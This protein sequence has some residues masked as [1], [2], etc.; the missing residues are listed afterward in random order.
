[1]K[2]MGQPDELFAIIYLDTQ[3]R[4]INYEV[5]FKGSL[6]QTSVYPRVVVRR[7]LE[8]NAAAMVMAHNHPSGIPT[9]SEADRRLTQTL[10][11]A[12]MLIDVRVLD[13]IIIGEGK[14]Y[15][16]AQHGDI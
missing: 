15:S 9:P 5:L 14:P 11:D 16:F 3:H 13:H 4:V 1:M 12:L 8:M 10:R 7:A 2:L 6:S